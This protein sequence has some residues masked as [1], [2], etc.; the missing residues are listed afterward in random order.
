MLYPDNGMVFSNKKEGDTDGRHDMGETWE[1]YAMWKKPDPPK[2]Y[3]I[4]F[5]LYKM[6]SKRKPKA[7]ADQWLPEA[8]VGVEIDCRQAWGNFLERGECFKIR[9]W[10]WLYNSINLPKKSFY[11]RILVGKYYGT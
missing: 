4:W 2:L 8:V 10:C 3:I 5:H 11:C 1:R 9:L 6:P 7:T